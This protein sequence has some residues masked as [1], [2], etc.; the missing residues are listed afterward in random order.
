[1]GRRFILQ[2]Y[3]LGRLEAKDVITIVE[4]AGAI[5]RSEPNVVEIQDPLTGILDLV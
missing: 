5:L 3:T 1:M 2:I 4:R